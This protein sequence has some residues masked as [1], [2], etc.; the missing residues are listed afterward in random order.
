[1]KKCPFCAAVIQDAAIKCRHC[2]RKVAAAPGESRNALIFGVVML[3]VVALIGYNLD[4][5]LDMVS[6]VPTN[7]STTAAPASNRAEKT[8]RPAAPAPTNVRKKDG[9]F[10]QRENDLA[11]LCEDWRFYRD[12]ILRLNAAGDQAGVVSARQR[13]QQTNRWL[14]AYRDEDV[15]DACGP[16]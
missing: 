6:G 16:R 3:G 7:S 15:A 11:I 12:R 13:F 14:D 2:G 10:D 4:A 1:M 5:F 8:P 9:T